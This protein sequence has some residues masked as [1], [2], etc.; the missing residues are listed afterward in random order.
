MSYCAIEAGGFGNMPRLV[1]RQGP[2]ERARETGPTA[3]PPPPALYEARD[4]KLIGM[5]TSGGGGGRQ[6]GAAAGFLT[7]N[8]QKVSQNVIF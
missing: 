4:Q 5:L 7:K 2:L 6:G 3:N 1:R 8:C